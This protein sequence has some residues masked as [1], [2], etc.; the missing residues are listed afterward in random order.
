MAYAK[1]IS[2]KNSTTTIK[3]VIITV[4]ILAMMIVILVVLSFVFNNPEHRVKG[5]INE[6]VADYYENDM[7]KSIADVNKTDA[8][9]KSVIEKY[10]ETGFSNVPLRQILLHKNDAETIEFV[11]K[12]CDENKSVIKYYPDEPYG[13]TNYHTEIYYSCEF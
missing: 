5:I 2:R 13:K 8:K 12:Y 9:I 10:K 11:T 6:L 1:K 7:Y 4:I 3:N